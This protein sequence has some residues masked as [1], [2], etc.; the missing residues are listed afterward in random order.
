VEILNKQGAHICAAASNQVNT[1]LSRIS[2]L[3]P[4]GPL[5]M[6][7]EDFSGISHRLDKDDAFFVDVYHTNNG[8]GQIF[9]WGETL[10]NK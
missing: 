9:K 2:A 4:A 10:N 5:F 6:N 1:K 7:R 8:R 3:D